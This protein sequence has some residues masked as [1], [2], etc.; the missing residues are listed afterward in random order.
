MLLQ[1]VIDTATDYAQQVLY[2]RAGGRSGPPRG[3]LVPK[4]GRCIPGEF[5]IRVNPWSSAVEVYLVTPT[6]FDCD[7]TE[8]NRI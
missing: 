3:R 7:L 6:S 2:L 5:R 1:N 4:I 8:K